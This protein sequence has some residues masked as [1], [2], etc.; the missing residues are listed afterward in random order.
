MRHGQPI[1]HDIPVMTFR[2]SA[3]CP[4]CWLGEMISDG[5]GITQGFVTFYG[6]KCS[7][8]GHQALYTKS[9]PVIDHR[10]VGGE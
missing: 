3:E 10:D 4:K 1:T 8:C 5:T 9:Y 2:V 7:E 6:H